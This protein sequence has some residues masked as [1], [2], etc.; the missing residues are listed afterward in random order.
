MGGSKE[1]DDAVLDRI[2]HNYQLKQLDG[3]SNRSEKPNLK[4]EE[5]Q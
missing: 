3:H 5:V 1:A 4:N 2:H